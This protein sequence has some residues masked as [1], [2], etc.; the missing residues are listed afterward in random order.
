MAGKLDLYSLPVKA[1]M[2]VCYIWEE[3]SILYT[4]CIYQ[5]M[6]FTNKRLNTTDFLLCSIKENPLDGQ[7][8]DSQ[9]KH[10]RLNI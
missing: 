4:L 1:V 7:V 8:D 10:N 6:C 9:A 2:S 5:Q 3:I